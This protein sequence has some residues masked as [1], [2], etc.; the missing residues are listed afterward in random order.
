MELDQAKIENIF[1]EID[2][3]KDGLISAQDLENTEYALSIFAYSTEALGV[4][5]T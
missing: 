2:T 5:L 4:T 3:D 1:V